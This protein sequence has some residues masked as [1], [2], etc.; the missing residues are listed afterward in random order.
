[1]SKTHPRAAFSRLLLALA[2]AAPGV[3]FAYAE[4]DAINDCE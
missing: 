4:K 2:L 3:A 1:M